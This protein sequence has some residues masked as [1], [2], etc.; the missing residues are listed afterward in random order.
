MHLV[1]L[2][3]AHASQV[4]ARCVL[5]LGMLVLCLPTVCLSACAD[6]PAIE[7]LYISRVSGWPWTSQ[8]TAAC[9]TCAHSQD[10]EVSSDRVIQGQLFSS[11]G[12]DAFSTHLT[13]AGSRGG[14]PLSSVLA[15][16]TCRG[17]AVNS[18]EAGRGHCS[19]KTTGRATI[20]FMRMA[21]AVFQNLNSCPAR[22]CI[23]LSQRQ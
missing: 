14:L 6:M 15:L 20:S 19:S 13:G 8:L 12:V 5:S 7:Y 16:P 11:S 18:L 4:R 3:W 17:D 21:D 2:C 22:C 10:A 1:S 23:L 9:S